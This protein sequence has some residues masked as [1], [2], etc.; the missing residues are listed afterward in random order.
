LRATLRAAALAL[1]VGCGSESPSAP[2]GRIL[3]PAR[4]YATAAAVLDG[5]VY[6]AGGIERG[7]TADRVGARMEEYDPDARIWTRRTPM[8]TARA[9]AAA[10]VIQGKVF[11]FGGLDDAGKALATVEAYDPG[12][13]R[14]YP[15]APMPA[16]LDR[17][18]AV[19]TGLGAEVGGGMDAGERNSARLFSYFDDRWQDIAAFPTPRHGH[20]LV[21]VDG[22]EYA[23]GGYGDDGPLSRVDVWGNSE[24]GQFW[25]PGPPLSTPRGFFGMAVLGGRIYVVGGRCPAIPPTEVLDVAGG[26]GAWTTA[27]PLPKDL[28]R[29]SLVAWKGRL[30]AF[31]GETR[32]GDEINTDVLEFDPAA[33]TWAVR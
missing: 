3:R 14:W 33:G 31:G 2:D 11:V 30:L 28:C 26:A 8:P 17:L 1:L 5:K 15:C 10:A 19:G 32:F 7:G 27:A 6:I 29:F 23:V 20:G 22:L 18:A 4:R 24:R 13:D 21:E 16:A 9:F 25:S 12:D